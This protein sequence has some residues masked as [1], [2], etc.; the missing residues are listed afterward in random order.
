MIWEVMFL[1]L[2][3]PFVMLALGIMA[4]I[5]SK[6]ATYGYLLAKKRFADNHG[7]EDGRQEARDA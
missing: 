7:E 5:I 4:F 6:M 3:A 1:L 2:V